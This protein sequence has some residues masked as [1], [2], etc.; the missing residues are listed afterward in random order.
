[1]QNDRI[2]I[3]SKNK[4]ADRSN[5][6]ITNIAYATGDVGFVISRDAVL[7]LAKHGS[8]EATRLLE[9]KKSSIDFDYS[10]N[11]YYYPISIHNCTNPDS[12]YFYN[13]R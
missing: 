12:E 3:I 1:M 7:W 4:D 8:I 10:G 5:G 6:I 11:S 2:Q 13:N 9:R